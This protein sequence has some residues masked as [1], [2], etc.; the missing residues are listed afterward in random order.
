MTEE[1]KLSYYI[2]KAIDLSHQTFDKK[3]RIAILGSFT[4]NGLAE[5]IQ[6]KCAEKK[7][8]CITYMGSYNQYNQEIL[9]PAS[10]L[11]KFKPDITLLFIDVRAAIKDLF[12][13][14]YSISQ[15]ERKQFVD[16]KT[17][18]ILNLAKKFSETTKSK[19]VLANLNAPTFSPYGIFENKT[20]FGF[21]RMLHEI[22]TKLEDALLNSDSVYVYDFAKF[23]TKFGERHIFDY[24]Q[25]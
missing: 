8:Q 13:H 20:E 1:Q 18:E 12:H 11:Y 14:P 5:T 17:Q 16:T 6:V 25:F 24:K 23:V 3:I 19:F 10:D 7:I 15:E 21:K 2:N 22:N 9:N 4:L